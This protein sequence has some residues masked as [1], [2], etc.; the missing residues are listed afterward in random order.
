MV[1]LAADIY[2]GKNIENVLFS[3]VNYL[4]LRLLK[5]YLN[6]GRPIFKDNFYNSVSLSALLLEKKDLLNRNFEIQ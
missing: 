4:V 2:K 5:R 1:V 6:K 3:K